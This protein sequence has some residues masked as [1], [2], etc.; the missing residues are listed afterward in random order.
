MASET[1]EV[2]INLSSQE[3]WSFL[4]DMNN[5]APLIPDYLSHEMK[6]ENEIEWD[7][8][9]DLGF[10]KKT[11]KLKIDIKERE[12][13]LKIQFDLAG[14]SDNFKG[15]GHFIIK[16]IDEAHSTLEGFL[17]ISAGGMMAAMVNPVL[18]TFVPKTVQ[19]LTSNISDELSKVN[20]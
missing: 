12:E 6:S 10:I 3:I 13:P 11:V 14:I 17:D 4:K 20:N 15:G 18:K 2:S 9:A 16:S 19:E 5:W 8:K 1:H 7:F